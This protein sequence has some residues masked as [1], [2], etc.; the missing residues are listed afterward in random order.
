MFE[1]GGVINGYFLF[2]GLIDEISIVLYF[3]V[4]G[5]VGS[6]MIFDVNVKLFDFVLI[7]ILFR[8]LSMEMLDY[9]FVWL[10]YLV[11]EIVILD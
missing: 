8:Y 10:W 4:D 7:S 5:Y 6:L 2:N 9:G 3:G 11:D 1:G